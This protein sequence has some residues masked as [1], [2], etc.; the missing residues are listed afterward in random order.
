MTVC[1][2]VVYVSRERLFDSGLPL[3]NAILL[4]P[5]LIIGLKTLPYLAGRSF[6]VTLLRIATHFLIMSG[7]F[8]FYIMTVIV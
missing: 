8:F 5:T 2:I 6:V 7:F 1:N 3:L 4:V